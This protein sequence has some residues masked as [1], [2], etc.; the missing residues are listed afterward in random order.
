MGQRIFTFGGFV[1]KKSIKSAE[2]YDFI[3]NSWKNL[4]NMLEEGHEVRCERV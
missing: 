4:P 2:V 3:H 1:D